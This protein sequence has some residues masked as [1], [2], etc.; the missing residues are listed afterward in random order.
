MTIHEALWFIDELNRI[1]PENA[2][3]PRHRLTRTGLRENVHPNQEAFVTTDGNHAQEGEFWGA[4]RGSRKR[5]VSS[6]SSSDPCAGRGVDH[7]L[8]RRNSEA[9]RATVPAPLFPRTLL[10]VA[11]TGGRK[12]FP[13]RPL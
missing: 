1:H 8:R 6:R 12:M 13:R 3:D 10:L 11:P 7:S 2:Q 5:N 4:F 9:L